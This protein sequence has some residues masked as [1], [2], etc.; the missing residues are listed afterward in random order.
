M[1]GQ[2]RI[3]SF[4]KVNRWLIISLIVL[5]FAVYFSVAYVHQLMTTR[6][7]AV[8]PVKTVP[9]VIAS[10]SIP[11]YMPLTASDL[12]VESLPVGT[13]PPGSYSQVSDLVGQ[14]SDEAIAAGVPV[15]SA[16]V[17][18]PK[19]A[20]ILAARIHPGDM[21]VDLPLGASDA[22][23]GLIDPGN[24]ISLFTTITEKNGQQ[25]TE[26]FLNDIKVLA[27]NGS[28]TPPTTPTTGQGLTLILA[29]PP[30]Q[31]VDLLFVE[32]KG[33]V[34]AALDAPNV[35]TKPPLPYGITNWQQPV[36]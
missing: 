36:P 35:H 10:A 1:V 8:A 24:T 5:G 21:A 20:N 6:A 26:D 19:T 28:L 16:Q 11:A 7:S 23:D 9:V 14:W 12:T 18:A 15:V 31:I 3:G 29:L 4:L 30:S 34:E 2:N 27:V 17:F 13:V 22:V 33:P 25:V 32:Q